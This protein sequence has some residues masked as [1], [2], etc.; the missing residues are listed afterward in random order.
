[1]QGIPVRL[2]AF[3]RSVPGFRAGSRWRAGVTIVWTAFWILGVIS[4]VA[5]L[6]FVLVL[7]S[8]CIWLVPI[9]AA[10]GIAK[11][12][13]SSYF[14]TSKT[15]EAR[16]AP[17]QAP[18]APTDPVVLPPPPPPPVAELPASVVGRDRGASAGPTLLPLVTGQA[19]IAVL[20][21]V[22]ASYPYPIARAARMYASA[23]R[24]LRARL[25]GALNVGEN[26]IIM[27]AAIGLSWN[28]GS[29]Q[30]SEAVR[31]WAR[32]LSQGGVSL[33][34]WLGVARDAA[35]VGQRANEGIFGLTDALCPERKRHRLL[36]ALNV[37]VSARNR[38][39]HDGMVHSELDLRKRLAEL[40]PEV[41]TALA[42]S[43]FLVECTLNLVRRSSRQRGVL[44]VANRGLLLMGDNPVFKPTEFATERPLVEDSIYLRHLD[45]S[46]LD[47]SPFYLAHE[48]PM[49]GNLEIFYP[50][51]MTSAGTGVMMKSTDT[52][53][54][55]RD[56]AL[57]SEFASF[58]ADA[59]GGAT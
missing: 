33:G 9:V 49:C 56:D 22:S 5:T 40:E 13:E 36:E 43:A 12:F 3:I 14:R 42:H 54:E 25:E 55:F 24:D 7:E 29:A 27:L 46:M 30:R 50:N 2:E 16:A 23:D 6:S 21:R 37:I 44:H 59:S 41:A 19:D 53:H 57:V 32:S 35:V 38:W 10:W 47:L 18:Q 11:S 26:L 45:G 28:R 51:R 17:S 39:A 48:C 52:T 8:V 31:L 58:S 4:G 15:H 34:V 20:D 1:M